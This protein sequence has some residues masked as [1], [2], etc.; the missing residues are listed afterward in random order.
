[1][2]YNLAMDQAFADGCDWVSWQNSDTVVLPG[3]L[4]RMAEVAGQDPRVGVMGPVFRDWDSD[5][6]DYYMKGRHPSV[7]PFMEDPNRPPVDCDWVEGCACLTKRECV[8]D[9]GPLD[10]RLFMYWEEADFCRRARRRGWRV[11][12]VPGSINRHYGEGST[13]TDAAAE[14]ISMLKLRNYYVYKLCDPDRSFA[15]NVLS[16]A[17]LFI[18]RQRRAVVREPS[19]AQWWADTRAFS[20]ALFKIGRWHRKWQDDRRGAHPAKLDGGL[21]GLGVRH[22]LGGTSSGDTAEGRS[23]VSST[24]SDELRH[25]QPGAAPP[26]ASI[27]VPVRNRKDL[28]RACLE[29]LVHRPK[30]RERYEV[31]VCDDGSSEDLTATV[32]AFGGSWHRIRFVRQPPRGPAAA[33]NLGV[34]RS[35][36]P[37]V[38]FVDSDVLP[39]PEM[40]SR[41]VESLREHPDWVGAEA[42]LEPVG[43]GDNPLW[44]A[45]VS[46]SGGCFHTAAIAYRR[47]ALLA[48]GGLDETFNMPACEDVELAARVQQEGRIGFV[49]DAVAYHP[50]RRR[51]FKSNWKARRHWRFV[52]MMA[53]RCGFVAWP[54]KKT[55]Y[56][57]L[58]TAV[59]AVATLPLGRIREGSRWVFR[60]PRIGTLALLQ[61]A[62]D[63]FC[64]VVAVPQILSTRCRRRAD[65]LNAVASTPA[66]SRD[67]LDAA[68]L[69]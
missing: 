30:S 32:S 18:T 16:A 15:A 36:A 5:G 54:A 31:V 29:G 62:F 8:E 65:Y 20:S 46:R 66:S 42:R 25:P 23:G 51:T 7:I 34:R 52:A 9:V 13:A 41:L 47:S 50:R 43:G 11:V 55:R 33:R 6:P 45:P 19:I 63:V 53:C 57:R 59:S 61:A 14:R 48:A 64:G 40:V 38:V 22:L 4:H 49:P 39:Q 3:W 67:E 1:M 58:R 10:P 37:I 17:R 56:P 27:V 35:R 2:A 44:D 12:V 60:S 24:D 68:T 28:L 21:G 26:A 69:L